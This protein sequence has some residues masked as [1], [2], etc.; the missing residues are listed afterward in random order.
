MSYPNPVVVCRLKLEQVTLRKS[1]K[2]TFSYPATGREM[3][4]R[5]PFLLLVSPARAPGAISRAARSARR[6]PRERWRIV[7]KA[8]YER[9]P[10]GK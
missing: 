1:R 8:I 5:V 7:V 9:C 4:T 2:D 10:T 6:L 3:S